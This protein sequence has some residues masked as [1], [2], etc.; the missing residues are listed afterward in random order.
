MAFKEVDHDGFKG[1]DFQELALDCSDNEKPFPEPFAIIPVDNYKEIVRLLFIP[2]EEDTESD[3]DTEVSEGKIRTYKKGQYISI[4]SD[5]ML[6]FWS[7]TF[8]ISNTI[9]LHNQI[10][11]L[12]YS[13]DKKL[14]VKDM[15]YM[16]ELKQMA[17]GLDREVLFCKCIEDPDEF[18][19][20]HSLVVE[21]NKVTA[22][23]YW[24]NGSKAVFSYG[25]TGGYLYVFVTYVIQ[26]HS[27]FRPQM[28]E[29]P[30]GQEYPTIYVSTMLQKSFSKFLCFK[31]PMFND[32]CRQVE[33]F[34]MI[35]SF[36][37]CSASRKMM[38]LISLPASRRIKPSKKIFESKGN[39]EFFRCFE[40][41]PLGYLLTG[42]TDGVVR[43]WLPNR[44]L[45]C[46]YELTGHVKPIT[47]IK[48]NVK[49]KMFISLSTDLNVRV[50]FED[51][52][53]RQS[54]MADGMEQA[55]ISSVYY[56]ILNNEL[57]LAN[58][59][60]AKCLGR[61]TDFC[62]SL[63]KKHAET[64]Y[65][66]V[67]EH[68]LLQLYVEWL[69]G[70]LTTGSTESLQELDSVAKK[71]PEQ[72][73]TTSKMKRVIKV[74]RRDALKRKQEKGQLSEDQTE[75]ESESLETSETTGCTHFID[76]W[77]LA[78]YTL[79]LVKTV[80]KKP[81]P[82]TEKNKDS[83]HVNT[84]RTQS[85][86]TSQTSDS[87]IRESDLKGTALL[88]SKSHHPQASHEGD[89]DLKQ[90]CQSAAP[91]LRWSRTKYGPV[92]KIY[93]RQPFKNNLL[94]DPLDI[95]LQLKPQAPETEL[96]TGSTEL[97]EY[98]LTIHKSDHSEEKES[99]QS[100]EG[101][102]SSPSSDAQ[103]PETSQIVV[104][105]DL[106][107]TTLTAAPL[108]KW[109]RTKYGLVLEK[110]D[111]KPS[112]NSLLKYRLDTLL[113]LKPVPE[114]LVK[115]EPDQTSKPRDSPVTSETHSHSP[116]ALLSR[117]CT[118][119][120]KGSL[121]IGPETVFPPETHPSQSSLHKY[122]RDITDPE[123][124]SSAAGVDFERETET[125]E[126]SGQAH[127]SAAKK[128]LRDTDSPRSAAPLMKWTR[129]KYGPVL[130]LHDRKPAPSSQVK[131][132]PDTL[133]QL[134]PHLLQTLLT[135]SPKFRMNSLSPQKLDSSVEKGSEQ[136]S[137]HSSLS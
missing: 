4:S 82:T 129:T 50:W 117:A 95:L 96:T 73:G 55:P 46:V 104:D 7:D 21:D 136:S 111:R 114:T 19:P 18:T 59:N 69:Q 29:Q 36:A 70:L 124:S 89:S 85:T 26:V 13:H 9:V 86:E 83:S 92:L 76:Y 130:E 118:E 22:M 45:S 62:K 27:L 91:C 38:A 54:F 15:V 137:E 103:L 78:P 65:P 71:G 101:L 77:S 88:E 23:D 110:H 107:Q 63:L 40:Y 84:S 32:E 131:E 113:Q 16:K 30:P 102:E 10:D 28:Y 39:Y 112:Q 125:E 5:G 24:S 61:G 2:T 3:C 108:L 48:Y 31:V 66:H 35:N 34:P 53:C 127:P 42:G 133:F 60:I 90:K 79:A 64:A 105:N 12:P 94:K 128:S 56:N 25:D 135:K 33:F 51:L 41:W 98:S 52:L 122:I 37:V 8:E 1:L 120:T 43:L 132:P 47:H 123:Q 87:L 67:L 119:F 11:T 14:C 68:C 100:S 81:K 115:E 93:K 20:I 121:H 44:T 57:V 99:Q 49:D 116:E 17:I 74:Q 58:S 109:I 106:E 80:K 72:Q 134:K 75:C 97:I 6:I 126:Q